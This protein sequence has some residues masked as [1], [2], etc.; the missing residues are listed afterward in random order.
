MRLRLAPVEY[1]LCTTTQCQTEYEGGQCPQ[2]QQSFD[3]ARTRKDVY[4]RLVL[5]DIDPPVYTQ[6]LRCRCP[7][8]KNVYDLREE[9][10][11][12]RAQCQQCKQPL[13][14]REQLQKIWRNTETLLQ[15]ARQLD[16]AQRQI[17]ACPHCN[18]A[19]APACWCP[20]SLSVSHPSGANGLSQNPT[21]VWVRTFLIGESLEELQGRERHTQA[22]ASDD[23]ADTREPNPLDEDQF[24]GKAE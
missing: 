20:L 11:I 12:V 22:E 19:F 18:S 16:R 7:E 2:C 10:I 9:D 8:C 5:V 3:P 15:R 24:D 1:K 23:W 4:D 21:V 13:F 14:S 17:S 6:T